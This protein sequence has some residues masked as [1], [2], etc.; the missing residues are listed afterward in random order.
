MNDINNKYTITLSC[1][2]SIFELAHKNAKLILWVR[3]PDY[4]KQLYVSQS[5]SDVWKVSVDRLYAN[6]QIFNEFII[7]DDFEDFK[8]IVQ[9]RLGDPEFTQEGFDQFRIVNA[10]GEIRQIFDRSFPI[11][12]KSGKLVA[13]AGVGGE[14]V[15]FSDRN[16][17]IKN[18]SQSSLDRVDLV[19]SELRD[20]LNRVQLFSQKVNNTQEKSIL[21]N[22]QYCVDGQFVR[23]SPRQ[24]DCINSSLRG[25]TAKEIARELNISNRTVE[26]HLDILRC[27]INVRTKMEMVG[28]FAAVL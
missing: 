13:V 11:Y 21:P 17:S 24:A 26:E 25:M 16:C 22:V 18:S 28:K 8:M 4:Q 5:F 7:K 10:D 12:E 20:A 3:S 15:E 27:K 1:V 9:K 19:F 6:P 14:L 2:S 23:L